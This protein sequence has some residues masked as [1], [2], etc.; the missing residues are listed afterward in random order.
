M[1]NLTFSAAILAGSTFLSAVL[2]ILRDRLLASRFGVGPELDIYAAAFRIPDLVY[3]FLITGGLAVAF[4]PLFSEFF[5]RDEKEG[6]ETANH[7]LNALLVFLVLMSSSLFLLSPWLVKI[8]LPGFSVEV[9]SSALKLIRLL[10]LSPIFFGLA[11]IFSGV[12]QY[13]NRFF[14]YGLAPVIYNLSIIGGILFLAPRFGIFGVGLGVV[15]GAFLY[16]LSQFLGAIWCGFSWKPDFL[17]S[18]RQPVMGRV[19]GLMGPRTMTVALQQ[20]NLWVITAMA[21]FLGSGTIAILYFSNNLQGFF[22]G[23]VGVSFGTAAFPWLSRAALQK[24]E[25]EF[26]QYLKPALKQVIIL[27][28]LATLFLTLFSEKIVGLL[29]GGGRFDQTAIE[30]TSRMVLLFSLSLFAQAAIPLL[31]R[32]FFALQ[33][34]KTPALISFVSFSANI[35]ILLVSLKFE[36][37]IFSLALAFSIS[38][39]LQFALLLVFLKKKLKQTF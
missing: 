28:V 35:L 5:A 34:A 12:L 17:S 36:L 16:F 21:S 15:G 33:E 1:K 11:N 2:G 23:L 20:L 18:F 37:G 8:L 38:S 9:Q 4:L 19:L 24:N 39:I 3:T 6:W 13:F 32:A 10:L 30:M 29:F 22:V 31:T 27:A 25:G 26:L 7:I 14:V